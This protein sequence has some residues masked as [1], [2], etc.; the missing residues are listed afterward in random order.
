MHNN[1]KAILFDVGN[2]LIYFDGVK[3][4]MRAQ[5]IDA[6]VTCLKC[7][8][9]DLDKAK[10]SHDFRTRQDAYYRQ[11]EID[12]VERTRASILRETLATHGFP[13]VRE[14]ILRDALDAMLD[15]MK[16]FWTPDTEA[17]SLLETLRLRGLRLGILS[18]TPDDA[19]VQVLVD[20]GQIRSYFDFVISSASCGVRKPDPRIFNIALSR[21]Q[22]APQHVAMVGDSLEEDI[23]GG[24][25]AGLFT[26]WISRWAQM[27]QPAKGNIIP[28]ATIKALTE[29]ENVLPF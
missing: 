7:W 11:R 23:Q 6:M 18:N 22:I 27:D 8:G 2:T 25:Q 19:E 17:S 21:W 13:N 3:E 1:I 14:N 10:L 15:V 9:L 26:I 16:G 29:L 12:H 5:A 4:N 24:N 28:D 20:K